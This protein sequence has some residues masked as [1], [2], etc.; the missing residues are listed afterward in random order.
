MQQR[1]GETRHRR[2]RVP[3]LLGLLGLGGASL[4]GVGLWWDPSPDAPLPAPFTAS[5]GPVVATSDPSRPGFSLADLG[6]GQLWIPSLSVEAPLLPG[7]ILD[8]ADGRTLQ[9]PGDP[10][11]VT[12]YD[13]GAGP[14]D[15]EGTVLVAGHVSV[16]GTKGAL[17][18]LSEIQPNA[19]VYLTCDDATVTTWQVASVEV[20]QKADLPQ[21][22]FADEGELRAV[23]ITCGGPVLSNGHYRD[24]VRVELRRVD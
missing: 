14:C 18:P 24:N 7:S 9:I 8:S 5:P 12:L 20:S 19:A 23:L 2:R 21:D 6:A 11:Q 4:V 10:S 3:V 16:R 13:G 22:V 15:P 17:Y 1:S